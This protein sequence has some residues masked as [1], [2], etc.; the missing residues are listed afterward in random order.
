MKLIHSRLFST[1]VAAFV[2]ALVFASTKQLGADSSFCSGLACYGP[3]DCGTECFCNTSVGM[4][5][6]VTNEGS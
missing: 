3:S 4:C 1:V 2:L 5:V 6:S